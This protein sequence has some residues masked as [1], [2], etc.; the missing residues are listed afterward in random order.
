MA[1]Q[2]PNNPDNGE[3]PI[4]QTTPNEAREQYVKLLQNY[5]QDS[6]LTYD[7][8]AQNVAKDSARGPQYDREVMKQ[9]LMT[10]EIPQEKVAAAIAEG[11]NVQN[12]FKSD[13]QQ[14]VSD[15]LG[16]IQKSYTAAQELPQ[17]Q[18]S[19]QPNNGEQPDSQQT[20]AISNPKPGGEPETVPV[21][22][23]SRE[24][25]DYALGLVQMLDQ[26]RIN[27]D[28]LQI[29]VNGQTVF[30][31]RDGDIDSRKTSIS[32]EHTELLKKALS[33]PA[34]LN[35]SV[36]IT[37]G[38]Q[39]LLHVKDGRVLIDSAGLT[40]QSAKVDVQA[41][42][43]LSEGLYERFSKEINSS[44][45]Q[46]TKEIAA[47]AL[48]AGVKREQVMEMLKAHDSSYQKLSQTQGEKVA[49]QTLGKMVDAAEV[50][51]MQEKMPQQQQS[52]EVK[53]SR[54]VKV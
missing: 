31:M 39:T 40:K 44:G 29:D 27:V 36:K 14:S 38:N 8:L 9:A 6:S 32:N 34:S 4:Q 2:N 26:R 18:V 23:S 41:P 7:T 30:K 13:K 17:Q 42:D 45:L 21:Q 35:G 16:E 37:Q 12:Q 47:N 43:S 19:N 25:E 11:P 28:R 54:S 48:N 50:K 24:A 49:E 3:A 20:T 46:A 1:Q 53:A 5:Y 52:Q 10:T 51:L 33:D 22:K 15:Y